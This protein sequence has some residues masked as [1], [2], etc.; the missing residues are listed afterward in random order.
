MSVCYNF[1]NVVSS[2]VL[3][4]HR[5]SQSDDKQV[6]LTFEIYYWNAKEQSMLGKQVIAAYLDFDYLYTV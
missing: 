4:Q 1:V 2:I 5:H 3:L 6:N